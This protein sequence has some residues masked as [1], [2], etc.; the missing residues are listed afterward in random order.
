MNNY[1]NSIYYYYYNFNFVSRMYHRFDPS[2]NQACLVMGSGWGSLA[3]GLHCFYQ[4]A[5]SQD[6]VLERLQ[7]QVQRAKSEGVDNIRFF[8]QHVA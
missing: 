8:T 6:G 1:K 2:A 7:F 5:Y 3:F 4:T